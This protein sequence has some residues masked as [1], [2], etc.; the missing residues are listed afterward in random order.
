MSLEE[1]FFCGLV[2]KMLQTGTTSGHF[3]SYI[4][5]KLE[6]WKLVSPRRFL[7]FWEAGSEHLG[8]L[9]PT[10]FLGWILSRD[11][12]IFQQI[13]GPAVGPKTTFCEHFGVI[14]YVD[15]WWISW[16]TK[17]LITDHWRQTSKQQP[18]GRWMLII[19]RK[20]KP[21]PQTDTW[22]HD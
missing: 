14:F 13:E 12:V 4:T 18:H 2:A 5:P 11:F 20:R 6:S 17:K 22:K 15:F 3:C 9:F 7:E 10:S 21:K 19:K 8:Q 1:C 16:G